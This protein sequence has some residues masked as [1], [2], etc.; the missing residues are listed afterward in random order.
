MALT[1]TNPAADATSE[2][3]C[4]D[5]VDLNLDGQLVSLVCVR[6]AGH[7]ETGEVH[8]NEC[9]YEWLP[10]H[11]EP[12]SANHYCRNCGVEVNQPHDPLC[13]NAD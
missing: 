3:K 1:D 7:H 6:P 2:G 12:E 5:R 10:H 11:V 9:C 8:A 4:G 13:P